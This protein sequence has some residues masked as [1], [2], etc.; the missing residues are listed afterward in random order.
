MLKAL[1]H[2]FKLHKYARCRFT[3]FL[4]LKILTSGAMKIPDCGL[5]LLFVIALSKPR[6][7]AQPEARPRVNIKYSQGF[8]PVPGFTCK[9]I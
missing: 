3:F 6:A 1:N 9:N 7:G 2:D 8:I 4:D 5:I